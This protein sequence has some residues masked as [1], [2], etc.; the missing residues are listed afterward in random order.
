MTSAPHRLRVEHLDKPL[1]ILARAPRLSWRLP[2]GAREQLRYRLRADNDWDTGWIDSA[3]S[4]L[5][6][7]DGPPLHATERVRWQVQVATDLGESPWSEHSWFETGLLWPEDWRAGW[8]E[9]GH[10][11]A[12][13]AGD[14]PAALLRVEFDVDRPVVSARLHATAQGLYEAFVNGER[15]GDGELTPGFTQYDV[16]LQVQTVDITASLVLGRNA[17]AVI[18]S[19]GWFRGQVGITRSSD[20]WG[21]RLAL[22]AQL[23][24]THADGSVT[25]IG[26]DHGWRSST[27]HVLAADLIAGQRVD[28]NRMP[29]GW[30][31]SRFRRLVLVCRRAGGTRLCRVGGFTGPTG[32]PGRGDHPGVGDTAGREPAE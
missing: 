3:Q 13:P 1:G 30:T 26:S 21:T 24:L 8:I 22:L 18:L 2:H 27:G 16:R 4:L 5:V 28:L 12:G 25:V 9:P 17:L 20:Q 7:Y 29:R 31:H 19:D 10:D 23:Q 32:T 15:A 14:R 6:H 11:P